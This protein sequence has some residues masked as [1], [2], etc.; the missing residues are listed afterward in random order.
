ML[1]ELSQSGLNDICP[2]QEEALCARLNLEV[3]E[4][5]GNAAV[6]ILLNKNFS[7]DLCLSETIAISSIS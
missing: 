5:F 3:L 2:S 1:R 4:S 7:F 6:T